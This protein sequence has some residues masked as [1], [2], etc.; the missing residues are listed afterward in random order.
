M[1]EANALTKRV[2]VGRQTLDILK[3][4]SLSL[5][6][7]STS[8]ILGPSGSGKST[9]L[10]LLAGLDDPTSGWVRLNDTEI[11][12]LDERRRA[13]FRR[14]HIGFVFQNYQLV[15]SLTALEN[16][17][18]PLELQGN[19][20]TTKAARTMLAEVG[21]SERTDHLPAQ[22]SG[23][24]QQRVA[25]ARAFISEPLI[26]FADEPTGS[27]DDETGAQI[28]EVMLRMNA[29]RGTTL[30]VVTHDPRVASTADRRL[31]MRAGQ[32][33]EQSHTS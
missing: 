5:P 31:T 32:L 16:V 15:P 12:A 9:L 3:P 14:D 25:L 21:L 10:S 22:L 1:I 18:L 6:K 11:T 24:E 19:R 23:G 7:G 20:R 17:M 8:V 13:A 2:P 27:L 30:V 4:T 28:L 26:L 33:S 29:Q